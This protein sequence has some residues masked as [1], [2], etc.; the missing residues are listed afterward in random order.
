MLQVADLNM[1]ENR[2][3]NPFLDPSSLQYSETFHSSGLT[4]IAF[5]QRLNRGTILKL[6]VVKNKFY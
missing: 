6:M 4:W 3:K 1:A 5:I 2:L